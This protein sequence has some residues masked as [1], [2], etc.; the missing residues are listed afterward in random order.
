MTIFLLRMIL[1]ELESQERSFVEAMQTL[2]QDY[3]KPLE[4]AD[5]RIVSY[6]M[7]LFNFPFHLLLNQNRSAFVKILNIFL[8]ARLQNEALVVISFL[9]PIREFHIVMSRQFRTLVVF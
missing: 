9:A 8:D 2:V 7:V 6:E 4:Q 3:L 1:T 5:P